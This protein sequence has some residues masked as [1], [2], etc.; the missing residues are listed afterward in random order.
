MVPLASLWLP[1]LLSALLVFVASSVIHMLL[2]YHASDFAKLPN[3][4]A[5][6][7]VLRSAPPGDYFLPYARNSEERKDPAYQ[8]KA[9]RGPVGVVTIMRVEMPRSFFRSL[10]LWFVYAILVS[11]FAAYIA[12]RALG[13]GTEYLEVFRFTATAAF[14]GYGIGVIQQSIWWGKKW[15]ATVKTVIDG[16]VYGL[17]TGGV[18]GWLWPT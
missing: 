1:I 11:T 6:M 14:L 10:I 18:F 8:E 3:E 16:L 17:L 4:D 7:D 13:A 12:S 5:T 2:G 9:K 15:S